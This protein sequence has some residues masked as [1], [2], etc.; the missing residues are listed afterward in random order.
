MN[1]EYSVADSIIGDAEKNA[2]RINKVIDINDKV[3]GADSDDG[4]SLKSAL[5]KLK[6]DVF[7]YSF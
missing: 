2:A 1:D 3:R 4:Q 7:E 6:R 5:N